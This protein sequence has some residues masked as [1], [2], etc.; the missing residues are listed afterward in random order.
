MTVMTLTSDQAPR[1]DTIFKKHP[2]LLD[3]LFVFLVVLAASIVVFYRLKIQYMPGRGPAFDTYAILSNALGLAGKTNYFEIGRP[4]FMSFVMSLF[5]RAGFISE[6]VAYGLDCLSYILAGV[7]LFLILRLRVPRVFCLIGALLFLTV[8]DMVVNVGFGATDVMAISLSIW[9]IY[10]TILGCEKNEKFLWFVFPLFTLTFLTR[11]TAAVMLFP[12]IFY[13]LLRT[14][15]LR[16]MKALG[17]SVLATLPILAVD[18]YYYWRITNGEALIQFITP[19]RVASTV[20]RAPGV[21]ITGAV[22]P[23]SFFISGFGGFLSNTAAGWWLAAIFVLGLL[24]AA[25]FLLGQRKRSIATSILALGALAY[26][27]LYLVLSPMNFLVADLVIL[28]VFLFAASQLFNP[29]KKQAI[30]L[31]VLIWFVSFLCYHSHQLVKESRYFITLAPAA[32][33]FIAVGLSDAADFLKRLKSRQIYAAVAVGLLALT[34]LTVSV[35]GNS[36]YRKVLNMGKWGIPETMKAAGDWLRPRLKKDSVV[37]ADYFVATAWFLQRPVVAMPIFKDPRGVS[38]ELEKY[39]ADYFVSI[40]QGGDTASCQKIKSFG[41]IN[42]LARKK[43]PPKPKPIMYFIGRDLDHYLEDVLDFKYWVVRKK[44][45]F[46]DDT[47]ASI[48]TTYLDEYTPAQLKKYPV[49]V[50]FNFKWHNIEDAEKLVR[51]YVSAGGT[52]VIDAS[53]NSGLSFYNLNDSSFLGTAV[54]KKS[55][56]T[57]SRISIERGHNGFAGNINP[58]KFSKFADEFNEPW[59]G[60]TYRQGK[61]PA[62]QTITNLALADKTTLVGI[63]KIGRGRVI[64]I[65][66]NLIFHS[67]WYKNGEEQRFDRDIFGLAFKD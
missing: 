31:I 39:K 4:P 33:Y 32:A 6:A 2:V 28:I 52:V 64:W 8:P 56:T 47:S 15:L 37:Y 35:S 26:L 10:V 41:S 59:S 45:G 16:K 18:M 51:E 1:T 50:L 57:N 43:H 9:L 22:K 44:S 55:L 38:Q 17:I 21:T 3:A 67:F 62:G 34:V 58:G 48:G 61:T 30:D 53:G 66:Y 49:L 46:P 7:G 11:Y 5:F 19:L 29:D 14:N 54:Y 20:E 27:S 13:I 60:S 40:W 65:G 42:I 25:V 63:Q 36:S 24:M 23:S 12:V